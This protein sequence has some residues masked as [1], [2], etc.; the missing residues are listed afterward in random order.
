ARSIAPAPRHRRLLQAC[1][2]RRAAVAGVS[3]RIDPMAQQAKFEKGRRP[4]MRAN[5][6]RWC[7]LTLMGAAIWLALG[8][9]AAV[10]QTIPGEQDY[11]DNCAVCHGPLGKGDGEAVSVLPALKPR[12]LS[13]LTKNNHGQFPAQEIYSAIDGRDN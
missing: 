10:A 12:D 8:A 3:M 13:Q 11:K 1:Y 9:L 5:A 7:W 6:K 4:E 2:H